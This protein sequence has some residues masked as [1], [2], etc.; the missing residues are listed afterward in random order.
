MSAN[1]LTEAD[2]QKGNT[3]V[4]FGL[5]FV[6]S[7]VMAFSLAA[8]LARPDVS[9]TFGAAAGALAGFCWVG[10]GIAVVALFERRPW[11][12]ILING[13]YWAVSFTVMGAIIGAVRV[14]GD[15]SAVRCS[16]VGD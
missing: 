6:F 11:S 4:I 14:T 5:A 16:E 13:G 15:A 2:L 8:F 10:L 9:V 1:G 7:V 12:Y 3:G